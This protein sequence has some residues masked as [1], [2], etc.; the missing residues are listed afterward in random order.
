M[1]ADVQPNV[2]VRV[3]DC[4]GCGGVDVDD[5]VGGGLVG[6][7]CCYAED[8]IVRHVEALAMLSLCAVVVWF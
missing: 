6:V 4:H 1:N 8:V 7:A 5:L 2:C 3:F